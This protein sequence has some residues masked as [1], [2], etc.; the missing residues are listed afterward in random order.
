MINEKTVFFHHHLRATEGIHPPPA[1]RWAPGAA[2]RPGLRP[3]PQLRWLRGPKRRS[4]TAEGWWRWCG[5]RLGCPGE[6]RRKQNCFGKTRILK[7]YCNCMRHM[8]HG[9]WKIIVSVYTDY[10]AKKAGAWNEHS[11]SC[12]AFGATNARKLPAER[13]T[14]PVVAMRDMAEMKRR[15]LFELRWQLSDTLPKSLSHLELGKSLGRFGFQ[16]SYYQHLSI[17]IISI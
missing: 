17:Y 15:G 16:Q 8:R 14:A 3:A 9:G 2:A 13:A 1:G 7:L 11:P 12:W 4:W 5:G 6:V 10:I